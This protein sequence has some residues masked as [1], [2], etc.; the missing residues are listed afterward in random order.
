MVGLWCAEKNCGEPASFNGLGELKACIQCGSLHVTTEEPKPRPFKPT[1]ED[2]VF[3]KIQRI[4]W[5]P[6]DG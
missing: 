2:R 6:W 5:D 1:V 3:L 4:R